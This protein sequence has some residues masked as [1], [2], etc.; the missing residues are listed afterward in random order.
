MK[1]DSLRQRIWQ[2]I[3]DKPSSISVMSSI[4]AIL[5]GLLIGFLVMLVIDP[6]RAFIGLS[7]I[8]TGFL[9]QGGRSL[10][11]T[12]Y[13]SAPL[14]LTGVSV[15][16]AFR[17]GLF[18][19]GATGQLT[20]G[21]FAAVYTGI[22]WT[23][24]GPIHWIVSVL[25]AMLAGALWGAI[26]GILKAYRNVNEVVASI[27]LNYIGMYLVILMIKSFIYNRELAR[28]LAPAPSAML[29]RL[30]QLITTH[31]SSLNAGILV[32]LLVVVITHIILNKTT[33]GYELKS[34][35]FNRDAARYAGMNEKR[36]IILAMTISGAIAGMAG[37][38]MYLIPGRFIAIDAT[39]ISEGFTG[40]AISLL[41]LSSPIGVLFAGLFYGALEMGGFFLQ[42]TTNFVPQII[43]I[44]IAVI[45]YF[46]AF[47]LFFQKWVAQRIAKHIKQDVEL[48]E[49]SELL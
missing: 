23:F 49:G 42:I 5:G 14:I 18:N 33:F 45:I 13:Y 25:M 30:S 24:L 39:L 44:I 47:A 8:L 15:A 2:F 37:A 16:F 35:G 28:A 4:I 38:V 46:S 40:I 29:P 17:T 34:V 20:V 48:P 7:T 36:N 11:N 19:I 27:M 41:G 10:G 1:K 22:H 32:A 3:A 43:E 9:R 6:S 26:P 31:R 12:V 21:A